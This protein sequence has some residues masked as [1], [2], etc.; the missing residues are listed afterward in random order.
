MVFLLFELLVGC[1]C[2]KFNCVGV[3]VEC[4]IVLVMYVFV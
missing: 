3:F 1:V 2:L 4:I